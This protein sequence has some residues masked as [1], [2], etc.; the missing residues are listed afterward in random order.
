MKVVPV[1]SPLWRLKKNGDW[2]IL[3]KEGIEES[4]YLKLSPLAAATVPLFNGK[5]TMAEISSIL[6]FAHELTSVDEGFKMVSSII[7]QI[8]STSNGAILE[9]NEEILHHYLVYDPLSFISLENNH[10]EQ[11][12]LAS[13]ISIELMFSN[14]CQTD[15]VYCYAERRKILKSK[16]LTKAR[17]KE[18]FQEID[19]LGIETVDLSGGDPLFR[20]DSV[21]LLTELIYL[22]K[23]FILSTK[24]H[25][26]KEMATQ[27]FVA[28]ITSQVNGLS[29]VVQFSLDCYDK[30]IADFLTGKSGYFEKA[31][32]SLQN[33][34]CL[35]SILRVKAV[36]TPFNAPHIYKLARY[37][38][39][40]G[41][42]QLNCTSYS[43]SFHRHNEEL[44]LG[45]KDIDIYK[46]QMSEI[47]KDFSHMEIVTDAHSVQEKQTAT[48]LSSSQIHMVN[49]STKEKEDMWNKR[50]VCSGGRTS[51]TIT[52]DGKVI[53]CDQISQNKDFIVGDVSGHT[54]LEVW[55]S[56]K[57]LNFVYPA[58]EK[59]KNAPCYECDD[60]QD[61]YQ[62]GGEKGYCFR[63]SYFIYGN[64]FCPPPACPRSQDDGPRMN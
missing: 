5:R 48:N 39:D 44:F 28:G 36:V 52:P 54:I 53:L 9:G 60:K 12:R 2:Y 23:L 42:K 45:P 24:C 31:I 27:L 1:I 17:W 10:K 20:S 16:E 51:L 47:E 33:M 43:R 6:Y 34:S 41:I 38:N 59:F 56:E 55:N 8:N 18:I 30:K 3:K 19:Q 62:I 46:M 35:N 4:A 25:V 32:D 7:S 37:L 58:G 63:D 40:I 49:K 22:Q 15:C 14:N 26:T 57:M 11:L 21:D 61:C 50:S 64:Q 13:P 29:R